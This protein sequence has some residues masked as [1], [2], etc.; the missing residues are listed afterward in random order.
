MTQKS[1]ETAAILVVGA[2]MMALLM[3]HAEMTPHDEPRTATSCHDYACRL[4]TKGTL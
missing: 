2:I 4:L 3:E 1:F